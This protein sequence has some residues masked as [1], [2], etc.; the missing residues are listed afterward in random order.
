MTEEFSAESRKR[1]LEE[2]KKAPELIVRH[3]TKED[4]ISDFNDILS[5]CIKFGYV[6]AVHAKD[7]ERGEKDIAGITRMVR[8]I[9]LEVKHVRPKT[10]AKKVYSETLPQIVALFPDLKNVASTDSDFVFLGS[11]TKARNWKSGCAVCLSDEMMG[12]TCRCG[13]TEI[14]VFR[15][16][17][18]TVCALPC[19]AQFMESSGF[20]VDDLPPRCVRIG[21]AVMKRVGTVNFDLDWSQVQLACPVCRTKIQE[22]FQAEEVGATPWTSA[23]KQLIDAHINDLVALPQ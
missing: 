20:S 8:G 9:R 12:T 7:K 17:G 5:G 1:P 4:F 16:C 23:Q 18:H 19:F 10:V 14:V 15:P 6:N 21:T 2:E 13:H 3:Q 11:L 22:T